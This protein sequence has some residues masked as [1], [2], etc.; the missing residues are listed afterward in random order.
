MTGDHASHYTTGEADIDADQNI[1]QT[2]ILDQPE[3]LQQLLQ[4][5]QA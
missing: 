4:Q 1:N 2:L 3:V 5:L